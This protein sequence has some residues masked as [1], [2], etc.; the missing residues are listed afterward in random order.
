MAVHPNLTGVLDGMVV[1]DLTQVLAGPYCT[2]M[3]ADHGADVIKIEPPEGDVSRSIG[4]YD[5]GDT[6][7]RHSGYFHSV[8]RNKR[9]IA[10]D[11]KRPADVA[12]FKRMVEKAD[13][14]VENYR[15]GVMERLGLSYETLAEIN[16]RLVYAALRGFGDPRTGASPYAD[17]PAFDIVAQAM[18][19]FMS[20]TGPDADMPLKSGPGIGDIIPG[21][22][23]A[24]G[25]VAAVRHAERHGRGQFLDVAMYDVI[26][27]VCERLVYQYSVGGIVPAPEGNE[28]PLVNPFSIFPVTDGWVAIGC[29][30]EAQW[31]TLAKLIGREDLL[32]DPGL[33]SNADRVKQRARVREAIVAWTAPR[34]KREVA[35]VL[36][37]RVPIGPVNNVVDIFADPHVAAR[38]MLAEVDIVDLGRSFALAGVPVHFSATP[39]GVH[40][41]GPG[42]DAHRAEILAQFGLP[43]DGDSL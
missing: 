3:L 29:P 39:G 13:V 10:L 12:L 26:L 18:G 24:F 27:A 4:V 20:I 11:L 22:M 8:N 40:A 21:I 36:G 35:E 23:C 41:A 28:H 32:A 6:A 37:G 17:W 15:V 16:P 33:Q 43:A 42:F 25:I 34:S 5:P 9:S 1:L 19:G 2:M 31:Q 7:R 38:G 14:V 30:I